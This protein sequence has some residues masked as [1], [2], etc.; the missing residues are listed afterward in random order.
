M[1]KNMFDLD[2]SLLEEKKS[3]YSEDI[4][5]ARALSIRGQYDRALDIYN[6]ILDEDYENEDALIGLLRVHSKN[7]REFDGKI[8]EDDIFAIEQMAPDTTNEEYL[9]YLSRRDDYR[10]NNVS[11]KDTEVTQKKAPDEKTQKDTVKVS[12]PLDTNSIPTCYKR[13]GN[14]VYLGSYYVTKTLKRMPIRWQILSEFDGY[15]MIITENVIDA[16]RFGSTNNYETSSIRSWLNNEFIKDAFSSIDLD[17]ICCIDVDNSIKS[18]TDIDNKYLCN[19]TKDRIFL[20]SVVEAKVYFKN[21]IQRIA[22]ATSYAKGRANKTEL[23][24]WYLRTPSFEDGNSAYLVTN[25][26]EIS[27]YHYTN[28][29]YGI[30][31][32]CVIKL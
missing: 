13:D 19:N 27:G 31:P 4:K 23:G 10:A 8:I 9:N 30:R 21:D 11:K 20:L 5:K 12:N 22:V 26:G 3:D 16:G 15:A 18:T 28:T 7:F 32:A 2:D 14:H 24:D 1:T 6:K 25:Y 29:K 17:R